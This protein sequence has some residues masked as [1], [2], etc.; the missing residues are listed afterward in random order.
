MDDFL[1]G[2]FV[3]AGALAVAAEVATVISDRNA[4]LTTPIVMSMEQIRDGITVPHYAK[5]SG[6][7]DELRQ[8]GVE[9]SSDLNFRVDLAERLA[10][11]KYLEFSEHED[12]IVSYDM[13]FSEGAIEARD[14]EW[15]V[16]NL[17]SYVDEVMKLDRSFFDIAQSANNL[18]QGAGVNAN[19]AHDY[20]RQSIG[21][22]YFDYTQQG[23]VT[24]EPLDGRMDLLSPEHEDA[25]FDMH[26]KL[27]S[28]MQRRLSALETSDQVFK[29][30][31]ISDPFQDDDPAALRTPTSEEGIDI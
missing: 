18:L 1:M 19:D 15:N 4:G 30:E 11:H 3:A 13:A 6:I 20:V 2:A 16:D 14:G 26:T 12:I 9:F 24:V 22:S 10:E 5:I 31:A 21:L 25:V 17:S 29:V 28:L 23:S 8:D 7:A 27:H